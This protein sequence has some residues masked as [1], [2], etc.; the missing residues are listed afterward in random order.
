M[1]IGKS[2]AEPDLMGEAQ[3]IIDIMK[4]RGA[5]VPLPVGRG[6]GRRAVGAGARQPRGRR[7]RSAPTT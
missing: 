3:A 7:P 4:A 6:R 2:L 1:R 5:Q